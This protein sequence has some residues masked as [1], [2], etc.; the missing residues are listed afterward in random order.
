[1]SSAPPPKLTKKQKKGLA[2]RERKQ[3]KQPGDKGSKGRHGQDPDDAVL[4]VPVEENQDLAS[5]Q[6][7]GVE[8]AGVEGA[9]IGVA[10]ADGRTGKGKAADARGEAVG[11]KSGKRKREEGEAGGGEGDKPRPKKKKGVP[12]DGAD[13]AAVS[14]VKKKGADKSQGKQ[15][16][17]LFIGEPGGAPGP[18]RFG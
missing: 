15:R 3:G 4:E 1:M 11:G 8:A 16:F 14:A 18:H 10:P 17:I 6:V 7:S 9:A 2:F 12:G 5:V 13:E